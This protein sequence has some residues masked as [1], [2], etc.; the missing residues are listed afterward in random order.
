MLFVFC[1]CDG[2]MVVRA[3][4]VAR[5]MAT[6]RVAVGVAFE[7]LPPL[8][9]IGPVVSWNLPLTHA[10]FE[11]ISRASFWM[12]VHHGSVPSGTAPSFAL[13]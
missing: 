4:M 1:G 9:M 3:V 13:L 2:E 6:V 12:N 10:P 8:M 5:V 11:K 7:N